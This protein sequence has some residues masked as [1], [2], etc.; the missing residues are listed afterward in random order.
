MLKRYVLVLIVMMFSVAL[1]YQQAAAKEDTAQITLR[2]TAVSTKKLYTYTVK[3]GDTLSSII[4]N[5]PGITEE[6]IP[7][8][9]QLIKELNPSLPDNDQLEVGQSLLLPGKP[10]TAAQEKAEE[11]KPE[12]WARVH[13]RRR[14]RY[15]L[16]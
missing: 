14:A 11:N 3:K 8:N 12:V 13:R 15:Y 10:V 4:K 2:K 7:H 5:I 16:W 1:L 6:D 9:Y